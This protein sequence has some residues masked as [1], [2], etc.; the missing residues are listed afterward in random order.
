MAIK[1]M[2]ALKKAAESIV[3]DVAINTYD[4]LEYDFQQEI[5]VAIYSKYSTNWYDRTE[6]IPNTYKNIKLQP[7][8]GGMR[9][10]FD[11][12]ESMT[13]PSSGKPKYQNYSVGNKAPLSLLG[14]VDILNSGKF[15][16]AFPDTGFKTAREIDVAILKVA[17]DI[18]N[19]V[20]I[21]V[22]VTRL[23]SGVTIV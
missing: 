19:Y 4:M 11:F 8:K 12:D 1:N 17:F 6:A 22:S 7:I 18:V 2:V 9:A 16:N 10:L 14:L 21:G 20:A 15:G 23:P 13:L 5:K 3:T